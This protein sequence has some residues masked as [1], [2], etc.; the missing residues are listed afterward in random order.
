MLAADVINDDISG[1]DRVDLGLGRIRFGPNG[2]G[3]F[4]GRVLPGSGLN[5]MPPARMWAL[6]W[7][8]G[9]R[10]WALL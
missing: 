3:P 9:S 1:L 6:R 8:S 4:L 5:H 10:T 2:S 7:C